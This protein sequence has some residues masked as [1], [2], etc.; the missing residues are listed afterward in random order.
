MFFDWNHRNLKPELSALRNGYIL[1]PPRYGKEPIPFR[2]GV[3]WSVLDGNETASWWLNNFKFLRPLLI[4]RGERDLKTAASILKDWVNSNPVDKPS[5]SRAWDGHS[6]AIRA[7]HVACLGM[8]LREDWIEEAG[9]QHAE[10]LSDEENYQGNWNHG[11]DQNIGLLSLGYAF[12][13]EAWVS[14]AR[15]RSIAAISEMVDWQSVSIEQAVKYHFYNYVRF[16]DCE[17]MFKACG[18]PLPDNTLSRVE[19]MTEFVAHATKPDGTWVCIGDSTDDLSERQRLKGTDAEFALSK[20]ASGQRPR[21]RFAVY[22]AGYVFGRSGWGE[23]RRFEG[24]AYYT[25]RFGP[26]RVIHGHNDHTSLTYY[27]RGRDIIID[28]G[29]HGYAPGKWRDYLRSPLAHNVV[30]TPD[31]ARFQWN[32]KTKLTDLRIEQDWQSYRMDDAPYGD[33][34]RF[35]SVLFIQKPFEAIVV[36][37]SITGAS[38]QYEQLWHIDPSFDLSASKDGVVG[39]TSDIKLAMHQLWPTDE[40]EIVTG[41]EDPVQGWAGFGEADL[42]PIPTI[43]SRRKGRSATFLTVFTIGSSKGEPAIVSQRRVSGKKWPREITIDADG[44]RASIS[45]SGENTLAVI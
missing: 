23:E 28:G 25:V 33:T 44:Q 14:L 3:N 11:L 20:G 40:I 39:E 26:G 38:H 6:A 36:L 18:A 7:E 24:E 4:S 2:D 32:E 27:S 13:K 30:C 43:V 29:F 10:F 9:R 8:H 19:H 22:H 21:N 16:Q 12:Q 45:I 35:R 34:A 5:S 31:K 42:R 1:V 17:R 41:R 37:D 15:S